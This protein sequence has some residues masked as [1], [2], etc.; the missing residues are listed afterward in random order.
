MSWLAPAAML[1]IGYTDKREEAGTKKEVTVSWT[2]EG[3]GQREE[4]KIYVKGGGNQIC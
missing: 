3:M 1:R 4:G 2:L